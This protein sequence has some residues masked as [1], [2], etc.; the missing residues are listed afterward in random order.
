MPRP[1]RFVSLLCLLSASL[2]S[3]AQNDSQQVSNLMQK[4]YFWETAKKDYPAAL[5]I[6]RQI[7]ALDEAA[8]RY[9]SIIQD[10]SRELNLYFYAGDYPA[11]MRLA[12]KGLALAERHLDTMQMTRYYNT[13]GFI[14]E[15]QGYLARAENYYATYLLLAK[16]AKDT[17][18]TADAYNSI[19]ELQTRGERYPE[20]LN[21]FSLA[22][23]LYVRLHYD[24]RLAYTSYKISQVY[25]YLRQYEQ[26]L[27]YSTRVLR[28]SA[29]AGCNEYDRAGYYINAGDIYRDLSLPKEAIQ[30]TRRGL[31]TA[32]A[33]HHREDI[34]D[35]WHS[36]AA[37]FALQH[38]WD[39]AYFY[40]QLYSTLK[41]SMSNEN[42][43]RK[44]EEID[45]H[46]AADKKDREL[47]L[48]KAQVARQLLL[49][50]ILF[51]ST[52]VVAV[53][54][55]LLYNRRRLRQQAD[56][57]ARLSRQRAE[58]LQ[59]VMQAQDNERKRIAQDIHDT[60]GSMLSASKLNLSGLEVSLSS[61]PA[62]QQQCYRT[63]VALIDAAV[64]ELRNIAH[65]VMPASLSRIGLSEALKSLTESLS[66]SS[67]IKIVCHIHGLEERLPEVMEMNIYLI[68]LELIHNAVKHSGAG[69]LTIQLI[70][71]PRH[72]NIVVEDNGT[73][74]DYEKTLAQGKGM[75]ITSILSRVAYL[76]GSLDIDSTPAAGTTVILEIPYMP[77]INPPTD[78]KR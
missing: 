39:S 45:E 30:M 6:Y 28:L 26:A 29:A 73:G 18:M 38:R 5:S 37:I 3:Q 65:N 13:I 71:Y 48:Q 72:L 44:I 24:E 63:S 75:G 34:R 33:I 54:I 2:L 74:F 40:D 36:L 58:H 21:T 70:R 59:A 20:A 14:Y 19:G 31:L 42:T 7:T 60:L 52:L 1:K 57:E 67:R 47:Q 66:S 55:L 22:Y 69:L 68:L 41:D 46:Y 50:N 9:K 49:K 35:A 8:N 11:A 64:T 76:K 23:D 10:Y 4:G 77:P 62:Q 16:K 51:F 12:T 43:R 78:G 17:M 53:F 27:D 32:Q 61:L 56:Y 15:N 25:K